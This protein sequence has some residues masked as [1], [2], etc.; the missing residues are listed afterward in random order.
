MVRVAMATGNAL[1]WRSSGQPALR[2]RAAAGP[3]AIRP[4]WRCETS[5]RLWAVPSSTDSITSLSAAASASSAISSHSSGPS[6]SAAR[7]TPSPAGPRLDGG[8]APKTIPH[9]RRAASPPRRMKRA[10]DG[11][12][13]KA[14][15]GPA[16]RARPSSGERARSAASDMEA[17]SGLVVEDR[18]HHGHLHGAAG[19][20]DMELGADARAPRGDERERDRTAQ[21]LAL[22]GRG[23]MAQRGRTGRRARA[24]RHLCALLERDCRVLGDEP[25]ELLAIFRQHV[26]AGK[27][28]FSHEILLRLANRPVEAEVGERHRSVGLLADDDIALLGAHHMHRLGAVSAAALLLDLAPCRLPHGAAEMRGY[29]DLVAE[30]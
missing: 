21:S 10:A 8:S 11:A 4:I 15:R 19:H 27:R 2:V 1:R 3:V 24:L 30:F 12:S 29:I 18:R 17:R 28:A 9:A 25:D 13:D 23:D 7:L 22:V 14:N 6:Q 26:G 20:R 5:T 16:G